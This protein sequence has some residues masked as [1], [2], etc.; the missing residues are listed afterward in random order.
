MLDAEEYL[1]LAINA[2]KNGEHHASLEHLDKVLT[3]EPENANAI[4]LQA[5]EHAELGLY[6]RAIKGIE[7]AL[8][9]NENIELARF[10]L[11]MLYLQKDENNEAQQHFSYL[12][13]KTHNEDL[14]LFS[15]GMLAL[16]MAN[17]NHA[18]EKF[19]AG[20]LLKASY[21]ALNNTIKN[22]IDSFNNESNSSSRSIDENSENGDEKLVFL[23]AYQNNN[24]KV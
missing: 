16:S 1:A 17:V 5:A 8:I 19:T 15:E 14:S 4:Y 6:D 24:D 12:I 20:L 9:L 23:G 22:I 2:S 3:L 10:Q 11:G 21:P 7:K 18:Q 13:D